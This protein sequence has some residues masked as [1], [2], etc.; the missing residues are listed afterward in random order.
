MKRIVQL[1]AT[2]LIGLGLMWL[3]SGF[4][5]RGVLHDSV[6]SMGQRFGSVLP[7]GRDSG[8]QHTSYQF[9]RRDST[10]RFSHP[11]RPPAHLHALHSEQQRASASRALRARLMVW[12]TMS[13]C[14]L[15]VLAA[16]AWTSRGASGGGGWGVV[17]RAGVAVLLV[18]VLCVFGFTQARAFWSGVDDALIER[19]SQINAGTGTVQVFADSTLDLSMVA[20]WAMLI[21]AVL[22]ALP[23]MVLAAGL[24]VRSARGDGHAGSR[25]RGSGVV[26]G[27]S[28]HCA[29]IR[30]RWVWATGQLA[31]VVYGLLVL[32]LWSAPWSITMARALLRL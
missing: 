1:A 15:L 3:A 2:L 27:G 4:S 6:H 7:N 12:G 21:A 9:V 14:V 11:D 18:G 5:P 8:D 24:V 29:G 13:V 19:S 25:S 26:R 30:M 16:L 23:L 10:L 22:T 32:G 31:V 20:Y 17:M 28:A